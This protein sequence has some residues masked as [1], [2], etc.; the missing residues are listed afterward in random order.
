MGQYFQFLNLDKRQ[1]LLEHGYKFP[2]FFYNG[3]A[4]QDLLDLLLEE[5]PQKSWAGDR[6]IIAGDYQKTRDAP[7]S[8][9]GYSDSFIG[10][11]IVARDPSAPSHHH[12]SHAV[13]DER[14]E[15]DRTRNLY[16]LGSSTLFSKAPPAPQK[17]KF[18]EDG[19]RLGPVRVLRNLT[20][21]EYVKE[22]Q[23]CRKF[24][25]LRLIC[26]KRLIPSCVY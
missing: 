20:K 7:E 21:L 3:K 4:I 6:I 10:V 25:S 9:R 2:E 23:M 5:D 14:G 24:P 19:K 22:R 16:E 18:V 1:T 12:A 26:V 11:E 8:V 13:P 17:G 15:T